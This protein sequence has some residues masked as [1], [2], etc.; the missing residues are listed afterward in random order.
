MGNDRIDATIYERLDEELIERNVEKPVIL[1]LD[2]HASH[3]NFLVILSMSTFYLNLIDFEYNNNFT[4]ICRL[5]KDAKKS[6]LYLSFSIQTHLSHSQL[7][8]D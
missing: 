1:F 6:T 5:R 8:K 7:M 4:L 3:D 2:G